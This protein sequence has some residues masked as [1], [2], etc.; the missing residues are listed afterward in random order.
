LGPPTL[1]TPVFPC[2][3]YIVLCTS[4]APSLPPGLRRR[5]ICS[6]PH[7][8]KLPF[9]SVFSKGSRPIR[10]R[11]PPLFFFCCFD[12]AIRYRQPFS[13]NCMPIFPKVPTVSCLFLCRRFW[14]PCCL[15]SVLSSPSRFTIR[16]CGLSS[17]QINP[18]G[19]FF[20][21][22]LYPKVPRDGSFFI[23]PGSR[24]STY[25][26]AHFSNLPYFPPLFPRE[27]PVQMFWSLFFPF[28]YEKLP[29]ASF[30]SFS[31]VS[32]PPGLILVGI[33]S[34][35]PVSHKKPPFAWTSLSVRVR[36]LC[37]LLAFPFPSFFFFASKCFFF[38]TQLSN[39]NFSRPPLVQLKTRLFFFH[40]VLFPT[41]IFFF[42]VVFF[43]I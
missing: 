14:M 8:P 15:P 29:G 17:R 10:P 5:F 37:P 32:L 12:T 36:S 34:R 28:D 31:R 22:W 26:R 33:W 39:H 6:P 38:R 9:S 18:P 24:S 11:F 30:P 20:G 16:V 23:P 4:R 21:P 3:Q 13:P 42:T 41:P 7:H 35:N 25:H 1:P 27:T 43:S 40:T 19:P 2:T